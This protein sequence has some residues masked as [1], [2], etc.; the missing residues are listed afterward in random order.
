MLLISCLP[1]I[2]IFRYG[3][4]ESGDFNIHVY[5]TIS[6]VE[7]IGDGQLMPSWP[8][9]LNATYGY[10]LFIWLNS[11][12]Y[13]FISIFVLFGFSY[14]MS[15]K[16]FLAGSYILSGLTFWMF[17]KKNIKSNI[18][19]FTATILYLFAPYH[20]VD[21]HFRAAIGET[22]SFVILPLFMLA[23]HLLVDKKN[24]FS[25]LVLGCVWG[26]FILTH[27]AIA[28]FSLALG[29]LYFVFLLIHTKQ[30]S[31][32]N[33]LL[34]LFSL[35][36]GFL[37][38]LYVW[39]PHV[40]MATYTYGALLSN[41]MVSFPHIQDLL[42]SPYRF[43]LLFQ[44]PRG[45][46]SY[47]IGYIHLI[48]VLIGFV[49]LFISKQLKHN[50]S[51]LLFYLFIVVGLFI[52]M[53]PFSS[54]IWDTI[55]LIKSVQFST[56]LLVLMTYVTSLIGGIVVSTIKFKK[57]FLYILIFFTISLT[58]LNWGHR[59]II[60]EI[61]DDTLKQQLWLSTARG[62]GFFGLGNP[63]WIDFSKQW[64]AEKPKAHIEILEGKGEATLIKRTSNEHIY[65]LVAN[66][67]LLV[68]ENTLYFPGWT[69]EIDTNKTK[70]N[71]SH[72]EYP[73]IITFSVPKGHHTV[74][75]AYSDIPLL[76]NAKIV[77][78]STSG[79]LLFYFAFVLSKRMRLF[80]K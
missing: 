31:T 34:Y 39:L 36:I 24:V 60:P 49:L 5:R 53:T 26:V 57:L 42:F 52:M 66:S 73:G 41:P 37:L 80:L 27:H 51:E 62:E 12:P 18:A 77:S 69:L 76:R 65:S 17:A 68:K 56:R 1:V 25:V 63:K 6:F 74:R 22:F 20:F 9:D 45:E 7:A 30:L 29:T 3:T 44:G 11:L 32:R 50:R 78:V 8:R 55:P 2:S 58:I 46:L 59:R 16:L 47:A 35:A 10:P 61:T 67:D 70:I 72:E 15:A 28:V 13:Y 71:P 79:I 33:I 75:L 54:F 23:I 64:I 43:G 4:Y 21:L 38:S 14:I 19:V 48:F 40:L